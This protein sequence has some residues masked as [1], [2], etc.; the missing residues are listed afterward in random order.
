MFT[1][2]VKH[3][4][5]EHGAHLELIVKTPRKYQTKA[6]NYDIGIPMHQCYHKTNVYFPLSKNLVSR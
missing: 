6:F 2:C 1:S 3:S 4:S 5:D